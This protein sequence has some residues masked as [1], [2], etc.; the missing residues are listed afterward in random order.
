Y[1]VYGERMFTP[2]DFRLMDLLAKQASIAIGH[3]NLFRHSR[4][5]ILELSILNHISA[6]LIA[7]LN[8]E[9]ILNSI[10]RVVC[11]FMGYSV[12]GTF[13]YD[14]ERNQ[15]YAKSLCSATEKWDVDEINRRCRFEENIVG[16]VYYHQTSHLISDI[17]PGTDP[18]GICSA[19]H[20]ELAVP[21]IYK[22]K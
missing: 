6:T 12:C 4:K 1:E 11:R 10:A 13:L 21:L 9:D 14:S 8:I 17:V 16:W 19:I 15:L 18:T 5:R 7:T 22:N 20:S 2:A 3:A